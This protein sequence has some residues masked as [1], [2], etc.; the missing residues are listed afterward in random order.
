MR[1]RKEW[2]FQDAREL[3]AKRER[4]NG[5]TSPALFPGSEE[6]TMIWA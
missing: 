5:H 4:L 1:W 3:R 6:Y 2:A